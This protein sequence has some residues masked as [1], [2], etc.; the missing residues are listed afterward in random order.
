MTSGTR[1]VCGVPVMLAGLLSLGLAG[2]IGADDAPVDVGSLSDALSVLRIEVEDQ[3]WSASPGDRIEDNADNVKLRANQAGDTFKFTTPIAGGVYRIVLRHAKR[4]VYGQYELKANGASVATLD[5][6]TPTTG[7]S[8]TTTTLGER[9]LSGNVELTLQCRGKNAA[10]SGYDLKID[11]IELVPVEG[12]GSGGGGGAGGGAG[13]SGGGGSAE[14]RCDV[15]VHDP[16]DPPVS[17]NVTGNLGTHDPAIIAQEGT[18]YIQQTGPRLP[19]KRSTNLIDWSGAPSAFG[20]TNPGWVASQVPGATDLWAPDLSFF[21]GKYHLYYSASTFGS[22]SSCIG[23]ATRASM[24]SGSWTDHGSV[25][26]SRRGDRYNAIDPNVVVDQAGTPWLV[27]GSFWDGIR[28]VQLD[29]NGAR[30]GSEVHALASRGGGAIEAPFV[31]RRCGYY[32]LFVSFDR[33]C[34]GADSTY[35]I[36]VGRS[37]NVLGPYVDRNGTPMLNGGGSLVLQGNSRWRGPGHNAVLFSGKSAYNVFH[38]YDANDGGAP[39]LRVSELVW[40]SAGW[41]ISGGP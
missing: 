24:A 11:Y 4:N 2:C 15:G 1:A 41:P 21:G 9:S 34:S 7:D 16:S 37:A 10:A 29:L 14:D 13:G 8:W 38:A 22:Q 19:G 32:Y 12:G 39:K 40:D 5:A 17:L 20:S 18:F 28:A 6:Y 3:S 35:N 36:R 25:I 33:C 23:H 31:V 30:V 26:C 27:F